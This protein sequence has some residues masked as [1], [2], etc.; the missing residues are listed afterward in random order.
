MQFEPVISLL[1]LVV[2][3]A[4]VMVPNGRCLDVIEKGAEAAASL[5]IELPEEQRLQHIEA[6]CSFC[7]NC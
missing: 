6:R 5:G 3:S 7:V 4:E 2:C 1:N